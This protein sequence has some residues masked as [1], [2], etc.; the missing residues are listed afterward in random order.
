MSEQIG[1]G[2]IRI[3]TDETGV[4]YD[5]AGKR[6]GAG[7]SKGFLGSLKGIGTGIVGALAVGK[8]V[9]FLKSS[10]GGASDLNETISKTQV[11][12]G[13]GANAV[14]NWS[15]DS[16]AALGQTQQQALDA[17]STFAVFGKSAG[18]QGKALTGF[19]TNLT[20]LATDLASFN[21]TS[22][23]E[24]I[25]AIGAALRG[26][27]EPIRKYGVLLDDASL[28]QEALKQ[29]LIE[30]T[31]QA[32]TPQQKV[33][34]SQSLILK[35][36]SAAQ[37]DFARTSG[38]LANQS[39]IL[40]AQVKDMATGF[41]QLLL[42]AVLFVV[43]AINGSVIPAVK[44]LGPIFAQVKGFISDAFPG[45]GAGGILDFAKGIGAQLLPV[46][47]TLA[48]TFVG[49][50]LPAVIS[51]AG[52]LQ[53][54]LFPIFQQVAGVIANQIVPTFAALA[55][56]IYGTLYPAIFSIVT[57]VAQNLKPVFDAIVQVMQGVVIPTVSRLVQTIRT[58]LLPALEPI[59]TKVVAVI[60]WL[61]KFAAAILGKVL[62]PLLRLA[63]WIISKI[64]PAIAGIVV[65]VA[66][67]VGTLLNWGGAIARTI[68]NLGKFGSAIV[69]VVKGGLTAL[70]N[71]VASLP[72]RLLSLGGKFL[73]AGKSII[74]SFV[75][76]LK[77]AAGIVG[78]IVGNV[79]DALKGLINGA[80]DRIN[81]ALEFT[82]HL[83]GPDITINPPDIGHLQG[84]TYDWRGGIATVGEVGPEQVWLPPGARVLTA[85]QTKQARETSGIDY[86]LLAAAIVAAL[87]QVADKAR[88]VQF[89]LPSGDP[90][91]AAMAT[92][93][94]LATA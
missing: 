69:G 57:A 22:P 82:I 53:S 3:R 15:K 90:E 85:A 52:Y 81:S 77:N 34:A 36:T 14:V 70:F 4:D 33:L 64:V 39:R 27:A 83:P 18:L 45:G 61:L 8:A 29:G 24:A 26:E 94:R 76:G 16:A 7:Y 51:L 13:S 12:F 80:I 30:T 47:Q 87:Q 42:P 17:A 43:K 2:V 79:W 89:V 11:L 72:G 71:A 55:T 67:V 41:G 66:K 65:I 25:D 46:L 40:S 28:R 60:G 93:N 56:F 84:G 23:Q 35:Q 73:G 92:L 63:G 68:G 50:I 6:A 49:T 38:G 88:P 31:S 21:N 1:E 62:P 5:G 59:I 91:A 44:A 10:V 58:Q 75:N 54:R 20:G 48:Q 74:T 37:G 78:G 86:G 9:D 19:S 32:L